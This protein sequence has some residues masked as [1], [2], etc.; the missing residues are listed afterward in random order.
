M[1]QKLKQKITDFEQKRSAL[2]NEIESLDESKLNARPIEGK[3][4]VLEIVEHL[5]IAE[6]EVMGG[7]RDFEKVGERERTFKNKLLYR[8]VM[9]VLKAG[10]P[11]KVPSKKMLPKNELSLEEIR[12]QWDE[13]QKWF[14]EYVETQDDAGLEKAVFEHPVSGPITVEQA[15]E[16]SLA[17][18]NSHTG[19]IRKRLDLME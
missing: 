2:L 9:F 13:S 10:I 15:V 8:V 16:M 19:Q 12:R 6:R 17:H 11:V 1:N 3:W 18:L 5:V 14:R 7:M 4:S